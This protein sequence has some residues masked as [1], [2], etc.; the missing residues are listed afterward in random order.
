MAAVWSLGWGARVELGAG[1]EHVRRELVASIRHPSRTWHVAPRM[2]DL[3][4]WPSVAHREIHRLAAL[5]V[6]AV[7]TTLGAHGETR[8][9]FGVRF[10]RSRPINRAQLVRMRPAIILARFQPAPGQ[11]AA[12]VP[13]E[14]PDAPEPPEKPRPDEPRLPDGRPTF[15][16]LMRRNGF[17]RSKLVKPASE[18]PGWR[19]I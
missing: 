11:L 3:N 1:Q 17:D 4:R 14:K 2:R 18:R 7:Q 10:W 15:D 9:T 16:E 19:T 13:P 12:W 5:G 6:I 8:F